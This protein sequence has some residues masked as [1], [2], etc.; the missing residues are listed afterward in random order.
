VR[1][2]VASRDNIGLN[3][4][5]AFNPKRFGISRRWRDSADLN[6]MSRK[7]GNSTRC[8]FCASLEKN[9]VSLRRFR[10]GIYHH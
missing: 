6:I 5:R 4:L 8:F 10:Y 2:I 7:A 9:I 1:E 3:A